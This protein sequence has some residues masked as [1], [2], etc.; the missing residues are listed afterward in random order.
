M[1]GARQARA[2]SFWHAFLQRLLTWSS[3]SIPFVFDSVEES[4]INAVDGS[5]QLKR[6]WL[7]SLAAFIK[8]L[9]NYVKSGTDDASNVLLTD[10]FS[11]TVYIVVS[12]A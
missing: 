6:R 1:K 12:S 10:S 8:L 7:L 2:L 5:L 3:R 11:L 9:L 4:S